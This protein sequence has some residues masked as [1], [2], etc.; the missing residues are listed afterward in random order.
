MFAYPDLPSCSLLL[1]YDTS[2]AIRFLSFKPGKQLFC[3]KKSGLRND[4]YSKTRAAIPILRFIGRVRERTRALS[5]YEPVPS[6]SFRDGKSGIVD[7]R[8]VSEGPSVSS[9]GIGSIRGLG[10]IRS[11]SL[12]SIS[13]GSGRSTDSISEHLGC[14]GTASAAVV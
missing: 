4:I 7:S 3:L 8:E 6:S 2:L 13:Y 14:E 1:T 5:Q 11:I 9:S 12:S 10:S